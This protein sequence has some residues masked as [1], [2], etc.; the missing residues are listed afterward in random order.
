LKIGLFGGTF[1][2]PHV[3]HLVVADQA[4]TELELDE[5]WFAPVGQPTH[6]DG[7]HVSEAVHRAAMTRLA[8]A[9]HPC[10]RVCED[11][12]NRA[13]PHYSL[14]LIQLLIEKHP[15]NS[16]FFIIG[17]DSLADLP[18]WHQPTALFALVQPIVAHRPGVRPGAA[19]TAAIDAAVP[20]LSARIRW[21]GAP[22]LDLSSTDLRTRLR[23]DRSVR[24]LMPRAVA[25]YAYDNKLYLTPKAK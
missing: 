3:G 8:I 12:I 4:L 18:K 25:D 16:W 7:R 14:T 15:Q 20:G 6:K 24:Y 13:G 1:D 21:V 2:P 9:T 23:E 22:L 5:I 11:D 19:A 17:E 10:F